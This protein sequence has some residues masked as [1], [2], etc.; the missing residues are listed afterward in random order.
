VAALALIVVIIALAVFGP[1]LWRVDPTM[2]NIDLYGEPQAPSAQFPAG[3]DFHGRDVLARLIVG[4]RIS[5]AV[6]VVSMLINLVIGVGLGTIAGWVGGWVDT[7][8][9]RIVDALYSIPLLLIVII[10]QVFVKPLIVGILPRDAD[11]PLLLSPELMSIYLAL[12]FSNWLT[13][14]R[15]AR[16][17]VINQKQ[18]DYVSASRALGASDKRLLLR[19][20]LPNTMG[21]ILVAA[22]LAIPEAI[23][24]ESFLAFI[25]LGVSAPQASWGSL[26]EEG[27][28]FMRVAPHLLLYPAIAI[29]V[30]MLA[31]NLFGDGLRDALDPS[32]RR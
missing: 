10:L 23:F 16:A 1:L 15:L 7:V 6:G 29:S 31:F 9:M 18:L 27:V 30:T 26:A 14:A 21:P 32:G 3:T 12:G 22:T 24:I 4:A 13:M 17:E 28:K 19:H 5:L 25:G 2:Q 8:L 20:V 11:M